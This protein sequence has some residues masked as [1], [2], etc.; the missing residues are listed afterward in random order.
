MEKEKTYSLNLLIIF[1]LSGP[2]KIEGKTTP[3]IFLA[4]YLKNSSGIIQSV[5]NGKCYPCHSIVPKG[6]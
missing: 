3:P 1:F 5:P 4:Q 6:K 2:K